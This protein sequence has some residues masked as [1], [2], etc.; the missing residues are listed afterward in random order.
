IYPVTALAKN[1]IEVKAA[2]QK[3]VVRITEHGLGAYIFCSE[4][5]FTDKLEQAASAAAYEASLAFI[6]KRGRADKAAGRVYLGTDAAFAE[7]EK[8]ISHD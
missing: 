1:Q 5:V 4:E 3:D 8:R 2:A 6:I 7:V